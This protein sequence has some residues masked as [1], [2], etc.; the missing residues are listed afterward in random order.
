MSSMGARACWARCHVL[1][2][3][4]PFIKDYKRR[5]LLKFMGQDHSLARRSAFVVDFIVTAC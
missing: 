2:A 3:R 1:Q 5:W 4:P